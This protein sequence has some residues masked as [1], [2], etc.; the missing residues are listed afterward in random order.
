MHQRVCSRIDCWLV[1]LYAF[2]E[3]LISPSCVVVSRGLCSRKA[4]AKLIPQYT[5]SKYA[6]LSMVGTVSQTHSAHSLSQFC[7]PYI[8]S[9][10][11]SYKFDLLVHEWRRLG[12]SLQS[13]VPS[14]EAL[15]KQADYIFQWGNE[16]Y[17]RSLYDTL[18]Q[19]AI[20]PLI[21]KPMFDHGFV[22]VLSIWER[23]RR[24]FFFLYIVTVE[25]NFYY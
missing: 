5:Q 7:L 18:I 10:S 4:E 20:S 8:T 13:A 15:E 25:E 9:T 16:K 19:N 1:A 14:S 6:S 3:V 21:S 2:Q 24:L 17:S 12:W 11:C 23:K 22:E